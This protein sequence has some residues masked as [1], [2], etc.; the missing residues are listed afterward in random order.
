MKQKL[1]AT[2]RGHI[3]SEETKQKISKA[4]T[5][6]KNTEEQKQHISEGAKRGLQKFKEEQPEKYAAMRAAQRQKLL[7]RKFTDE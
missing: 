5:G 6:R 1:A 4:N 7:G 2:E 3:V